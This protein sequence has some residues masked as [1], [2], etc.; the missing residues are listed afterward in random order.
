MHEEHVGNRQPSCTWSLQ[1]MKLYLRLGLGVLNILVAHEV[2]G[3]PTSKASDADA[4]GTDP[5]NDGGC[6]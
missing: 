1:G 2:L 6:Q 4:D 3:H 5:I